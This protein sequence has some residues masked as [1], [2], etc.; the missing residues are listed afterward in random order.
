[1][2]LIFREVTTP[3]PEDTAMRVSNRTENKRRKKEKD[4]KK[5]KE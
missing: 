5:K 2:G 1:M 4:D 3:L